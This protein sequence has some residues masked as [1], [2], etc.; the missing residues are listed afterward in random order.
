VPPE[1]GETWEKRGAEKEQG[2]GGEK[3]L[4]ATPGPLWTEEEERRGWTRS[5]KTQAS[6]PQTPRCTRAP[7]H[8]APASWPLGRAQHKAEAQQCQPAARR[9]TPARYLAPPGHRVGRF[10]P[11][12]QG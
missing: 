10:E 3:S 5:T 2:R 7:M 11:K 6:G 9:P 8:R 4:L 1:C 12:P